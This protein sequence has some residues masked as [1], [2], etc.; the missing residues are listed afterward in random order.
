[1]KNYG[2]KSGLPHDPEVIHDFTDIQIELC[3]ICGK[4]FRYNKAAGEVVDNKQYLK[5]HIRAFAQPNGAT[6]ELFMRLYHPEKVKIT[7][8]NMPS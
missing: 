2:C 5:D 1:M 7:L 4:K 3:T 8:H 6:H